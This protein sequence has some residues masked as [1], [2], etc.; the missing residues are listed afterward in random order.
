MPIQNV[1]FTPTQ[2]DS[3]KNNPPWRDFTSQFESFVM[4]QTH[5]TAL[6]ALIDHILQRERIL[7]A[8]TKLDEGVLLT[9]DQ[10]LAYNRAATA[11]PVDG[12]TPTKD[13]SETQKSLVATNEQNALKRQKAS[14]AGW[15]VF[16]QMTL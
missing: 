1:R 8:S 15:N 12:A 3:V 4:Y 2:Y 9:E 13:N 10:I 6:I 7:I 5:G 16:N 11:L 14:F